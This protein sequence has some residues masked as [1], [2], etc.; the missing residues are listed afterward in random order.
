MCVRPARALPMQPSKC[1]LGGGCLEV[2]GWFSM[3]TLRNGFNLTAAGFLSTVGCW[4]VGS[5]WYKCFSPGLM[6]IATVLSSPLLFSRGPGWNYFHTILVILYYLC[7]L[8]FWAST[9]VC[10]YFTGTRTNLIRKYF[11]SIRECSI[12]LNKFWINRNEMHQIIHAFNYTVTDSFGF[13]LT[14]CSSSQKCHSTE[15]EHKHTCDTYII[16]LNIIIFGVNDVI[17]C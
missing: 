16:K 14:R 1:P 3:L 9:C 7:L 17:L 11:S 12:I 5:C 8:Y 4:C 6:H 15:R 13:C 2:T 10:V